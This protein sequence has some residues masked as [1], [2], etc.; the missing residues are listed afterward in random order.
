MLIFT[1]I[2]FG[3]GMRIIHLKKKELLFLQIEHHFNVSWS[4]YF[5][6][7]LGAAL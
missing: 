6:G 7:T 4:L 5:E 3:Y 1:L 2:L